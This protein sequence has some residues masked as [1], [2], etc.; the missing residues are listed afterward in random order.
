MSF[1]EFY[2]LL[3]RVYVTL[4]NL[5]QRAAIIHELIAE[6]CREAQEQKLVIGI[7]CISEPIA[8]VL[9][10]SGGARVRAP[11]LRRAT[12]DEFEDLG[13]NFTAN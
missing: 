12:A 4:L 1:A 2:E 10:P 8:N 9:S 11:V 13:Y 3:V 6:I 7:A 5:I